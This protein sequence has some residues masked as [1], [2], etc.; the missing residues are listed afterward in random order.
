[1]P[2]P[3]R[4][5]PPIDELF[6]A[7]ELGEQSRDPLMVELL[8]QFW[9]ECFE[10]VHGTVVMGETDV[11]RLESLFD[12]LGV[13]MAVHQNSIATLGHAYDIFVLGLARFVSRKLRF[14]DMDLSNF[15]LD[16]P[17]PWVR[18]VEAVAA[19]NSAQ[20]PTLAIALQPLAPDCVFP[21][22][23]ALFRG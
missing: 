23:V 21:L 6:T 14:P 5:L 7:A 2:P 22:G 19:G 13:P 8:E 20:A 4:N 12:L 10:D 11:A 15:L 16:W 1:M 18:Y 3:I 9:P 17:L